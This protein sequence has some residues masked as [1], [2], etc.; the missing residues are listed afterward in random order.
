[1]NVC[2]SMILAIGGPLAGMS[3]RS[4]ALLTRHSQT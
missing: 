2:A 3:V 1:M 4:R